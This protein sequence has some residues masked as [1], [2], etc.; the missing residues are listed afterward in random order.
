MRLI[1]AGVLQREVLGVLLAAYQDSTTDEHLKAFIVKSVRHHVAQAQ[2]PDVALYD[3]ALLMGAL[4]HSASAICA[5]AVAGIGLESLRKTS[6]TCEAAKRW[7]DA[8]QLWYAMSTRNKQ[9]IPHFSR[10]PF[11]SSS[12][13]CSADLSCL[14]RERG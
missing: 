13:A 10:G 5:Q 4:T 14:D 3:D 6:E 1:F 8:A 11:S 2:K 12:S 9:V 7:M